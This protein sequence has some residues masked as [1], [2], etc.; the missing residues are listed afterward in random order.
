V[1]DGTINGSE[2]CLRS[3]QQALSTNPGWVRKKTIFD[4]YVTGGQYR[5]VW[6]GGGGIA[7]MNGN[8]D[9]F[10]N[11]AM[12]FMVDQAN[13]PYLTANLYGVNNIDLVDPGLFTNEN[14]KDG[15]NYDNIQN[16]PQEI[17][18]MALPWAMVR[19]F[20]P[21]GSGAGHQQDFLDKEANDLSDPTPCTPNPPQQTALDSGT[22]ATGTND[23][24]HITLASSASSTTNF[25][26]N[27]IVEMRVDG[28]VAPPVGT[29][30]T[31]SPVSSFGHVTAYNG[32]TK[33]ATVGS[34][35]AGTPVAGVSTYR[36][37]PTA[38]LSGTTL[39]GYNT[40]WN[41][42][43]V[44]QVVA[45]DYV[46]AFEPDVNIWSGSS[47]ISAWGMMVGSVA[48]DTSMTVV[49]SSQTQSSSTTPQ[50]VRFVH[51]WT[52]G[53]CGIKPMGK[54]FD[55]AWT[56]QPVTYGANGGEA[57]NGYALGYAINSSNNTAYWAYVNIHGW[58][59]LCQ[60]DSRACDAATSI[61][62]ISADHDLAAAMAYMTGMTT[63]GMNYGAGRTW[64]NVQAIAWDLAHNVI[65]FPDLGTTDA[66][67]WIDSSTRFKLYNIHPDS[68]YI[69]GAAGHFPVPNFFGG[70]NDLPTNTY[71]ADS[72]NSFSGY[73]WTDAGLMFNPGTTISAAFK[74]AFVSRIGMNSTSAVGQPKAI[75]ED[76]RIPLGDWTLLPHQWLFQSTS[77]VKAASVFGWPFVP[78]VR[79]DA[80]ISFAGPLS[81]TPC[82]TQVFYRNA[83][84]I[85][86][87]DIW[88]PNN[89]QVYKCSYLKGN[90]T[91]PIGNEGNGS[92]LQTD[93]TIQ[94]EGSTSNYTGN[95][96]VVL[97]TG[98]VPIAY[99]DRWA[100]AGNGAAGSNDYVYARGNTTGSYT[101]A[102]GS[103]N[104]LL[105]D[106]A[107]FKLSGNPEVLA[108][109]TDANTTLPVQIAKHHH[110][111]QNGETE[112]PQLAQSEGTTT[113]PGAGGC[114]SINSTHFTDGVL[115]QE[116][117]VTAHGDPPRIYN[118]VSKW[119]F[120][121]SATIARDTGYTGNNGH[122]ERFSVYGGGS[123]GGTATSLESWEVM[124]IGTG[125][126]LNL[127]ELL[128]GD[129]AWTGWNT[130]NAAMLKARNNTTHSTLSSVNVTLAD[131]GQVLIA[132]LTPGNYTLTVGGFNCG[133]ITVAAGDNTA[134]CKTTGTITTGAVS[135]SSGGSPA[136]GSSL[137]G[138]GVGLGQGVIKPN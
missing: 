122:T 115:E 110:F 71:S 116:D 11:M 40:T 48:S 127:T 37:W 10:D 66:G 87:H 133:S 55:G 95:G 56:A 94:F 43:G 25:Y 31:V 73:I 108:V 130:S 12:I 112:G 81:G 121:G 69:P 85:G 76:V 54:H 17:G 111:T 29:L 138:K 16:S 117:G 128:H 62:A 124:G 90:D 52:H 24:T 41:T 72:G 107:H 36:V 60:D 86:D 14:I 50:I 134:Y 44:G 26:V 65:G 114:A 35:S 15:G 103:M 9:W 80:F 63:G 129:S 84:W 64:T 98:V 74:G 6:D 3:S 89:L 38:T 18:S 67:G 132:G 96:T 61:Q 135:L 2:P 68:A 23:T 77:Q 88:S 113:C 106:V 53:M 42:A 102:T 57:T 47:S 28:S 109:F 49:T 39:T 70:N 92:A 32:S 34:W 137:T 125:A 21:T 79:S 5:W 20:M 33:V 13:Q 126:T 75:K 8:V 78:T 30:Y 7:V 101:L 19:R 51:H 100:S 91:L 119:I 22:V 82:A 59:Q 45:R 131:P 83:T 46:L 27:N 1:F 4:T 104:W 123:V 105:E 58:L 136:G 99:I 118:L 97:D 120:P 93:S